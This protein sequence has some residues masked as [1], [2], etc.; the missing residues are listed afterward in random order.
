MSR[1]SFVL[2]LFVVGVASTIPAI[3]QQEAASELYGFGVHAYHSNRHSEALDLFS[4]SITHS[5]Q[6]PRVFYFRGLTQ[7]AM[8]NPEAAG[9][10]FKAG[11]QLEY[12]G[13]NRKY[14]IGVALERV[15]GV[16]R[17]EIEG[18]R[19]STKIAMISKKRQMDQIKY[20]QIKKQ[21]QGVI[22]DT[23]N[24]PQV[25]NLP[26]TIA[27]DPNDPFS[28]GE[29][30]ASSSPA[31][32]APTP[33]PVTADPFAAP[34]PAKPAAEADPFGTP[35][36]PKPAAEA[37]P[38]GTP[39]PPKPAAEA[40]PFGTPAPPKPA[41]EADP[42]G[43]PAPAKPAA[44][45]DPFGTPAPAKPAAEADPFGTP[46][47]AKPAA[48][49]DPFATPGAAAAN[50][51]PPSAGAGKSQGALGG[52]F[53]SFGGL[54]PKVPSLPAFPGLDGGDPAEMTE[55]AFPVQPGGTP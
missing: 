47:P 4:Q 52:L 48:E 31:A 37:D 18:V 21:E 24:P 49:A 44:E 20:N 54:A 55:E 30:E 41:A 43:T 34:A 23:E 25:P 40:D 2:T 14:N 53:R 33:A 9:D 1:V 32:G 26:D 42:F 29:E 27:A 38:F 17:L 39:A 7:F 16:A 35:A 19:R 5:G 10:D 12:L 22:L 3:A 46:A 45:A 15:Q 51:A 8:G 6:D 50:T 28:K 36:P 13:S 11:A